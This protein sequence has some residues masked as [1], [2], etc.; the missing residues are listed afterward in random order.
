MRRA[1]PRLEIGAASAAWGDG[2]LFKRRERRPFLE[3][4]RQ[5]V[6]PRRG[7]RRVIGYWRHR[8][9]RLPDSPTR[10]ALGF[11]C[12][13]YVCFTPFFGFHFFVAAALAWIL[14]GNILASAIGTFVGNPITFPFIAAVCLELGVMITGGRIRDGI[15]DMPFT[16]MAI[17]FL[18]N[19]ELLVFPYFIGGLA[20]G[21]AAAALSYF[22]IKPIVAGYQKRRRARLVA[23]AKARI[24]A[25]RGESD[26]GE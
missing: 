22:I 15:E 25:A 12:G 17:L 11:A 3:T 18:R 19:L 14:R 23:R 1:A 9:Q 20:P 16:E 4:A 26:A 24:A 8:M 7:W 13:V 5:W 2:M 21:I 10:I 6:A